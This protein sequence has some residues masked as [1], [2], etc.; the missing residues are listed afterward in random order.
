MYDD[1]RKTGKPVIMGG[2]IN[3]IITA[4][5]KGDKRAAGNNTFQIF[6]NFKGAGSM[7]KT[8]WNSDHPA[9]YGRYN[10]PGLKVGGY[11]MSDGLANLHKDELVVDPARTKVLLEGI[12]NFASG[13]TSTY[14]LNMHV[15]G[16]TNTDE[17]VTKTM[18][19]L[20][21]LEARKPQSRRG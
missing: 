5:L 1:M 14:N 9:V 3:H 6:S 11:T 18:T 16:D 2:D 21:R 8:G 20:K 12:D 15:N 19:A 13:S 7:D 17:L 10:I 4:M